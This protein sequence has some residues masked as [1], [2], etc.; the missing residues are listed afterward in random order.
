MMSRCP[1]TGEMFC[2]LEEAACPDWDNCTIRERENA[3]DD[4]P[5][6]CDDCFWFGCTE[7]DCCGNQSGSF[8]GANVKGMDACEDFDPEINIYKEMEW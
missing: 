8:F 3:G 1:F 4:A 7:E 2:Y 5:S 6:T